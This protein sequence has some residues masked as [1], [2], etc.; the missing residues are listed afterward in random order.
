[1]P[2]QPTPSRPNPGGIQPAKKKNVPSDDDL[3]ASAQNNLSWSLVLILAFVGLI[4]SLIAI[5]LL[6]GV[7]IPESMWTLAGTAI[8]AAMANV[9][10][11]TKAISSVLQKKEPPN[12]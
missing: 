7:P 5:L 10:D 2:D 3:L 1:M 12:A 8:G 6:Q 9:G 11:I 4:F